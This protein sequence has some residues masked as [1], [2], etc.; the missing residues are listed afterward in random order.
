MF[1]EKYIKPTRNGTKMQEKLLS[2]LRLPGP[3]LH[4]TQ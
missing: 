2:Y 4:C 3:Q 1:E